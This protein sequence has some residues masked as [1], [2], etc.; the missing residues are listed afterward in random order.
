ML[1]KKWQSPWLA[2]VDSATRTAVVISQQ[3][4]RHQLALKRGLPFTGAYYWIP[5]AQDAWSLAVFPNA[6]Y[7]GGEAGHV[8]VWED[9]VR[10]L[11]GRHRRNASELVDQIGNCPY[12]L[13][14]GRVVRLGSGDWGVAHGGD[15][16]KG[17]Y[18]ESTVSDAF[19]LNDV[20][21]RFFFDEHEQMLPGD[22]HQ[23][24]LSIRSDL[25]QD[26]A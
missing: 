20:H 18:L 16:P 26:S 13:P 24:E 21:P 1:K 11:A 2:D 22:R 6:F 3:H 5:I 10:I 25:D 7:V 23:V 8:D 12:G 17:S 15:Q 9:V 4:H 14:R 19:C